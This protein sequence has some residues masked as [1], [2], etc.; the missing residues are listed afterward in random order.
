MEVVKAKIALD[1]SRRAG[2]EKVPVA[3]F[4]ILLSRGSQ[5]VKAKIA[6]DRSRR[7]AAQRTSRAGVRIFALML[8]GGGQGEK[9]PGPLA[10]RW[11]RGAGSRGGVR[12]FALMRK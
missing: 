11:T 2:I 12:I 8:H 6:L 1:R 7:L 10:A 9:R 5:V 4:K 3:E